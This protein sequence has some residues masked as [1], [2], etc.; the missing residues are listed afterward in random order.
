MKKNL[1]LVCV[2]VLVCGCTQNPQELN[3][4]DAQ[5]K[6]LF[7]IDEAKQFFEKHMSSTPATRSTSDKNGFIPGDFTVDWDNAVYS[8]DQAQCNIELAINAK[9]RFRVLRSEYVNGIAVAYS[10]PA[11]HKLVIVKNV[12]TDKISNYMMTIIPDRRY[13]QAY[14]NFDAQAFSIY[15]NHVGFSGLIVYSTLENISRPVQVTIFR[16][17][18]K[19]EDY[20]IYKESTEPAT[21]FADIV[22]ILRGIEVSRKVHMAT[23]NGED[24]WWDDGWDDGWDDTPEDP[25]VGADGWTNDEWIDN[26]RPGGSVE[27]DVTVPDNNYD[28]AGFIPEIIVIKHRPCGTVVDYMTPDDFENHEQRTYYCSKCRVYFMF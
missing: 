22:R 19:K 12:K 2:L 23:R 5:E 14:K 24:G 25:I 27:P 28:D 1:Y 3:S 17:G 8:S 15:G 18:Q 16:D 26:T 9:Y 13:N 20:S 11:Y 21:A 6:S 7:F 10:V 4:I